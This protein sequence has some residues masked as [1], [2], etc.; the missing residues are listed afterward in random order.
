MGT[1]LTRSSGGGQDGGK[2]AGARYTHTS[3]PWRN[4]NPHTLLWT[5]RCLGGHP[6]YGPRTWAQRTTIPRT[7]EGGASV[8]SLV[9]MEMCQSQRESTVFRCASP[10]QNL[11]GLKTTTVVS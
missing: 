2:L 8:G 5:L 1:S 11:S 6:R 3:R 10:P 7:Q 9:P 4:L